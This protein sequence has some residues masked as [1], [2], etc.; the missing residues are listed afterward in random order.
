M[1]NAVSFQITLD[2]NEETHDK[3]RHLASGKGSYQRILSNIR[4]VLRHKMPVTLR[5]NCT[6]YNIRTFVDVVSDLKN[7]PQEYK[8]FVTIDFQRVWQDAPRTDGDMPT[9]QKK[10]RELFLQEGFRVNELKHIDISRCYAD[11]ANDI[12]VNYMEIY[13]NVRLGISYLKTVRE[14]FYRTVKCDGTK[15]ANSVNN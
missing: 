8:N 2:G 12:V 14:N 4:M 13:I 1:C 7:L 5:L 15:N 3:V 9:E 11:K 6:G 10:L